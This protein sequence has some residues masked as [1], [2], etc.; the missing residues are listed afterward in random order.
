MQP[1]PPC[2]KCGSKNA[3]L[4]SSTPQW[5]AFDPHKEKPPTATLQVFNCPCGTSFT[6]TVPTLAAQH[7]G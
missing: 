1:A 3:K 2:P 7:G 5:S 6:H 4:F